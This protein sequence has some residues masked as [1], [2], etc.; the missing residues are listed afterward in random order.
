MPIEPAVKMPIEPAAI[1]PIESAHGNGLPQN[2]E[3]VLSVALAS[4][5]F[6]AD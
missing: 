1:M 3:A 6:G 5:G 2:A 4:K